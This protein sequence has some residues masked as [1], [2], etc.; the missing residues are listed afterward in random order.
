MGMDDDIGTLYSK[1][2]KIDVRLKEVETVQPFLK[3][4]LERNIQTSE[5]LT[6]T[7]G[8]IQISME[9]LND[10]MEQQSLALENQK[11]EF[12]KTNQELNNRISNLDQKVDKLEEKGKFDIHM[13]LKTNWP[14]IIIVLGLGIGYVSKFV[15]F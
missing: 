9:H 3:E 14:W 6:N 11:E 10:K 7:L 5:K 8:E 15:K 12:V 4:M 13:F 2:G 1:V